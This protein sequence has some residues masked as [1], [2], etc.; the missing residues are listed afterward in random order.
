[1]SDL[2]IILMVLGAVVL[3]LV[4]F[5][6]LRGKRDEDRDRVVRPRT[7]RTPSLGAEAAAEE[8]A[9]A[10]QDIDA[11]TLE[12]LA[13]DIR[14][15]TGES[16]PVDLELDLGEPEP[17]V[18]PEDELIVVLHVAF[19]ETRAPMSEVLQVLG[20]EGLQFGHH[21]IWHRH[22]GGREGAEV[23]FSVARMVEPG[24]L[25]PDEAEGTALPGVSL[26]LVLPG[27]EESVDAFARML[28]TARR[29]A[30]QLE[31]EVLDAQRST[32]TKQTA[33]HLRE[34]IIE[35]GRRVP[36]SRRR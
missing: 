23:V 8:Q 6:S 24:T 5:T 20:K 7:K 28:A 31:G 22:A 11:D 10:D 1:M 34:Q 14:V 4:A 32:L 27:P 15:D 25:D 16:E 26:F 30:E 21:R 19:R 36:G 18:D 17:A 3:G 13:R 9:A 12:S 29:L 35:H 2:Q 33:K